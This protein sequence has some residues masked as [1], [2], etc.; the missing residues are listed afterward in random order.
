MSM[1][2][3]TGRKMTPAK[4][5]GVEGSLMATVLDKPC[6]LWPGAHS[7]FGYGQVCLKVDGKWKTIY[8]HHL[9]CEFFHGPRPSGGEVLHSCDVPA[10]YEP[11]HLRWG[12]RQMNTADAAERGR[13]PRGE[14]HWNSAFTDDQVKQIRSL[15]AGGMPRPQVAEAFGV[16]PQTISQITSAKTWKHVQ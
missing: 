12:T 4:T 6:V 2:R 7:K 13:M 14:G 11:T 9:S 3:E 15:R 10:C 8:V 16:H 1:T 5:R